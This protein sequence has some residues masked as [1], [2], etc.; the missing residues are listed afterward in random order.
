M[1]TLDSFHRVPD[2]FHWA[3]PASPEAKHVAKEQR[4][5]EVDAEVAKRVAAAAPAAEPVVD[6]AQPATPLPVNELG[7]S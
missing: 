2:G 7:G 4:A 5:A 1:P 6:D 3:D